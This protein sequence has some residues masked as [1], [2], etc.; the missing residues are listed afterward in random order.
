[1]KHALLFICLLVC[2]PVITNAQETTPDTTAAPLFS[3]EK[4]DLLQY[5]RV[6]LKMRLG[7][8]AYS[9][10]GGTH[11]YQGAQ[12][13]NE[14]TALQISGKVHEKI[15]FTFRNR[16]NKN[17]AIQTLDELANNIELAYIDIQAAPGLNLQIGKMF[18]YF[19]GYEYAMDPINILLYNDIQSGI[20]NYVTGVGATYQLSDAHK[21]GLQVLNSR[22][23]HFQDKYAHAAPNI[24]EPDWPVEFVVNWIGDFFGG[25]FQ[26]NY[27]FSYAEEALHKGTYFVTLGHRYTTDKFRIMYDFAYSNEEIDTKGIASTIMNATVAPEDKQVAQDVSYL[28]NWLRAEYQISPKFSASLA[29]MTGITSHKTSSHHRLRTRYGAVPAVYYQPFKDTNVRF[30][31]AYIGQYFDYSNY[32]ITNY[33]A[34]S[35]NRNAVRFGIIAPLWIL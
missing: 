28:G 7:F 25:K 22:T 32:A 21:I 6:D 14:Y 27:S 5:I 8:R 26:T 30:F 4:L 12:F 3:P 1:M 10:R 11:D 17:S 24:K 31:L 9:L 13:V 2:F 15:G 20:K 23:M 19:G 35:Y 18:A 33:G 16:F 29:L 34:S